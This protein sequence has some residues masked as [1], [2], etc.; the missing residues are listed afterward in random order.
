MGGCSLENKR[1]NRFFLSPLTTQNAVIWSELPE[2]RKL[3]N[4][5]GLV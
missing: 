2:N 3:V 5:Q 1:V 4:L